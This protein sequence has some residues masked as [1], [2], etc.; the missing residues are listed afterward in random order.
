[1]GEKRRSSGAHI[2]EDILVVCLC[3]KLRLET[4]RGAINVHPSGSVRK[5]SITR[6]LREGQLSPVAGSELPPHVH[7]PLL[8]STPFRGKVC[9][10]V[11]PGLR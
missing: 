11:M 7:V 10:S 1:M 5:G 4:E 6:R 9:Q 8:H 2:S 3:D